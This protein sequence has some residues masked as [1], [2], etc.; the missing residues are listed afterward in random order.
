MRSVILLTVVALLGASFGWACHQTSEQTCTPGV[1]CVVI[2][3]G[4]ALLPDG[5]VEPPETVDGGDQTEFDSGTT[6]PL[7]A[8]KGSLELC[9]ADECCIP[10]SCLDGICR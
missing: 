6:P 9:S 3:D 5:A 1:D 7:T 8:C 10:L 4:A 2:A